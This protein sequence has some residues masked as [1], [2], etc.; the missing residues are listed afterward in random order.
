MRATEVFLFASCPVKASGATLTCEEGL[1]AGAVGQFDWRVPR[2]GGQ[3]GICA[4]IQKQPDNRK[5]VARHRVMKRPAE[6]KNTG[7]FPRPAITSI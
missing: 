6:E 3:S 5:V 1:H 7:S 4:V 2:V